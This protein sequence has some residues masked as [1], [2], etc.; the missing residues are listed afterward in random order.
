M[1]RPASS[2]PIEEPHPDN[3]GEFILQHDSVVQ[4]E[5]SILVQLIKD[6]ISKSYPPNNAPIFKFDNTR[7]AAAANSDTLRYFNYDLNK[8]IHSKK[9][10]ILHPGSEFRPINDLRP[11]LKHHMDW[12]KLEQI[13]AEGVRYSFPKN[14]KYTDEVKRADLLAAVRK[15]NNNS[16]KHPDAKANILKNYSKEVRQAWMIPF[17]KETITKIIGASVIPIGITHQMTLDAEGNKIKKQRTTHDLSRPW[18]SGHSVN[19]MIDKDLMDPCLFG[20]CLSR[21]L[22][23][24][25]AMRNKYTHLPIFISKIDLDSA[26]RR[27]HVFI[28][29]ALLSFTIVNQFTYFLS[30]LPFGASDAPSKHDTPSNITVDLGQALM[31]DE[32]WDPN[33]V[34]SPQACQIPPLIRQEEMTP[35]GQAHPLAVNIQ[36]KDCFA[37]GYVDDLISVAIN[38]TQSTLRARHGI[39]LAAHTIFRPTNKDDPLPRN[40]I[41]SIAKLLA[42]SRL[43]EIKT[44]LGW[45]INTRLFCISLPS[46]KSQRWLLDIKA[47]LEKID[48]KSPITTKEWQSIIGK[49]NNASYIFR[50]GRFFL[51]RLR[52]ELHLSSLK[53]MKGQSF[54][55][56]RITLDLELWITIIQTLENTGRSI[57]HTTITLPHILS[58]SDASN[59]GLGGYN[60]FGIGW[61]F[62]IPIHLRK[63]IHI[64]I[65]EFLAIT[66]TTWFS[67]DF[68][69][70]TNGNGI[71]LL[72]QS[73]NTSA[74]GWLQAQTRYDKSNHISSVLREYIG[75]KLASILINSDTSLYSQHIK[76]SLNDVADALSRDPNASN[77]SILNKIQMNWKDQLPP[78]GLNIVQLPQE[79][80]YFILSVLE[81][82]I[83]MME[84]PKTDRKKYK[85]ALENGLSS[86]PDATWTYSSVG[87]DV[88]N[89]LRSS[90]ASR[91]ASD[92]T[93]LARQLSMNLEEPQFAPKSSIYL[94]PSQRMDTKILSATR[95]VN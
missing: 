81:K 82:Q 39:A 16:A 59:D 70:I 56:K 48:S 24:I 25:H 76:G 85:V 29:H 91:T 72:G 42:E 68:L 71:K 73:D 54:G 57:N 21:I 47:I 7:E 17:N 35:F 53:G 32:T 77:H 87:S 6:I 58:K 89:K 14:L 93:L 64:N 2:T 83:L 37:D 20:F 30:R 33:Q 79:I 55:S 69:N 60:C 13:L 95:T 40:D 65:L 84:L 5:E 34:H 22:H 78:T 43:E 1:F 88:R 50:E 61:R 4:K 86:Q 38:T 41:L 92:I 31:D 66:I 19:N 45:V 67:I 11:L 10:T 75:R 44:V 49:L 3:S 26:F 90:V 46:E 18:E 74:L 62:I 80:S 9:N 12:S 36:A 8:A 94:R 27:I 23:G 28:Q 52:Y 63:L 51:S 15:G